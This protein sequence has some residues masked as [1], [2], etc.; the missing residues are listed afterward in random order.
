MNYQQKFLAMKALVGTEVSIKAR[1]YADWFVVVHRVEIGG[2]GLLASPTSTGVTPE[3]AI[4]KTWDMLVNLRP[5][6]YLVVGALTDSRRH[7]KWNG[8]M[9]ED[10]TP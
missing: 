6:Q 9:W 8:F 4:D 1:G 7:V 5:H 3:D 10:V 2:N